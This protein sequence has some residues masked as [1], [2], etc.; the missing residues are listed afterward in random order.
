[1]NRLCAAGLFAAML[2]FGGISAASADDKCQL[3][4]Y[5]SIDLGTDETGGVYV[6]MAIAGHDENLLVDTGG[7]V[8]ML[9]ASAAEQLSLRRQSLPDRM[10]ITMYGGLRI[11]EI[12]IADEIVL[13]GMKGHHIGFLVMPDRRMPP[14][15]SG[16]I[17]PDFM[18][19]YDVELDFAKAKFNLFSPDHCEGQ[20]VYWTQGAYA[21][22][23]MHLDGAGHIRF[24][25]QLDGQRFEAALDTGSSRSL[26]RYEPA[27]DTFGWNDKTESLKVTATM[28]KDGPPVAYQFPFKA[29]TFS[30]VAVA[31]P[32][33][34]LMSDKAS[35]EYGQPDLIIGMGI[36]RQLH[37]YLA[38]HERNLY[39][40]AADAH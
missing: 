32:D 38:Y 19:N 37:I 27:K 13:G 11:R 34:V 10:K 8:S 24:Y 14:E 9:T 7:F 21:Q 6:P 31:N 12:A 2:A 29:L 3:R 23:P 15:I 18:R 20:I 36:L 33:I 22:L 40:T 4:R 35:K 26:M 39:L 17:A 1:M 5:A 28:K 16:T 25:V 30:G